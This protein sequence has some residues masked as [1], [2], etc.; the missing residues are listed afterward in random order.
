MSSRSI[1]QQDLTD[2]CWTVQ[3]QGLKACEKCKFKGTADCG[4]KAIREKGTN[5]K[6]KQVPLGVALNTK[7]AGGL[8]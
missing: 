7:T 8:L 1:P 5:A 4:G 6:G 3:I 2:E